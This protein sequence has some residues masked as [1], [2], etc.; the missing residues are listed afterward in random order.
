MLKA[1]H[2][3]LGPL[4]PSGTCFLLI[5]TIL[6]VSPM[7][8]S[9]GHPGSR[10]FAEEIRESAIAGSWYPSSPAALQEQ[11][12]GF[13]SRVPSPR[14][15]GGL[16]ALISPHAGYAYSGQ[17]AAH[18]YKQIGPDQKF[19][20]VLILAP[21]HRARFSGV[22]LYDRGGFRTPFGVVPLD[23]KL[24]EDLKKRDF[25][26][27]Y[28]PDAH[29]HEH[30]LEIQLPFLQVVLPGFKL[31]PLLMGEQ[32]LPTCQW[33]AEAIV[34]SIRGKPV[35]VVASSDL[36]H[37][38]DSEKARK[39]DQQVVDRTSAFDPEG[40]SRDLSSGKCEACGGGPMVTAMLVAR[41]LG[42]DR[43]Q[44]LQYAHS[45][46]VTGENSRVVGYMA[47][48][49]WARTEAG[50]GGNRADSGKAG[51]DL[52]LT[53]EEKIL[54]HRIARESIEARCS[55]KP[56][57]RFEV[58]FARLKE[59]RGAF[60]TLKKRGELRGCIGH[61]VGNLPLDQTISEMAVAAAFHDPR[62]PSLAEDELN[63]LQVEI[64]VLS[65][66]KRIHRIEE[67]AVGTHGIY[68]KRGG[69]SGLLLPQVATEYGWNCSTFVENTCRKAGLPHDAWKDPETEIYVF[70][71]DIF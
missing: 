47:A 5:I 34:D 17:V 4:K 1:G 67:I 25:R 40:L 27:R 38:H 44:V 35:L 45:G 51:I 13:L 50:G 70:S 2:R 12:E 18:A 21:S 14:S 28:V 9:G 59:P 22:A 61:V 55:Q 69:R 41:K 36:S 10:A 58:D 42:A 43:S 30:S 6:T 31:V 62:F 29:T 71:A 56:P 66:L 16:I 37:F 19:E 65:P 54:L 39:L 23:P 63:E 64:S 48:A 7:Q 52:G 68:M 49:L 60:V 20:T 26:I 24:I 46:D 3:V 32:D 33:L 15:S 11:I 57:P 8:L 53:R